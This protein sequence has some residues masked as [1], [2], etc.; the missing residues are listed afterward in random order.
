MII[1]F[2]ETPISLFLLILLLLLLLLLILLL[3]LLLVLGQYTTIYA[4][5]LV[6][7]S[8]HCI[9]RSVTR[10]DSEAQGNT[11]SARHVYATDAFTYKTLLLTECLPTQM[12]KEAVNAAYE[13]TL[14]EGNRLE[15]RLFHATFA[16]NDRREGMTAFVEKRKPNFT[17]S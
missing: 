10:C 5:L 11:A 9:G 6:G 4:S 7:V 15:K 14:A 13:L 17:D 8:V 16:T 1:N 2:V 3:L 12:A